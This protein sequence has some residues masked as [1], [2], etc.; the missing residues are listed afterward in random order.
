MRRL[1]SLDRPLSA[2]LPSINDAMIISSLCQ[3]PTAI[4]QP[5]GAASVRCGTISGTALTFEGYLLC[6]ELRFDH[7]F[8]GEQ[9]L[10]LIL[11]GV[12]AIDNIGHE[13][14]TEWQRHVV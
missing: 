11:G 9:A 4:L 7:E 6:G 10:R 12:R 2:G 14:R 1:M 13:L 3:L 8:C 5:G